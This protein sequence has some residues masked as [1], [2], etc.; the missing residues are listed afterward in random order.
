MAL[1]PVMRSYSEEM[2]P[3]D[4]FRRR[5]TRAGGVLTAVVVL[6]LFAPVASHAIGP[7]SVVVFNDL[8]SA[9]AP[10]FYTTDNATIDLAMSSKSLQVFA[11]G[12][13]GK[14]VDLSFGTFD[15]PFQA[16]VY[17]DEKSGTSFGID[18]F[19]CAAGEERFEVREFSKDASGALKRLWIV[20]EYRCE[21]ESR[22]WF[23]EVRAGMPVSPDPLEV[24]PSLVRWPVAD[25]GR[26][27]TSVP[28]S[29]RAQSAAQLGTTSLAGPQPHDFTIDD[30]GCAGKAL[31]AGEECRVWVSFDPSGPGTRAA[32]LRIVDSAGGSRAV[33]LQGFGHGGDT[34]ASLRSDPGDWAG[35]GGSYDYTPAT[36]DFFV[37][38][39]DDSY[40]DFGVG[41]WSA[42]FGAPA[43]SV[44]LPGTYV[45]ATRFPLNTPPHPGL[46][47]TGG[48][49][50]TINGS[51]TVGEATHSSGQ[52][53]NVGVTFEQHCDGAVPAL[54]GSFKFRVGDT[55]LP[56]PWMTPGAVSPLPA[57]TPSLPNTPDAVHA[58]RS[59]PR[60][61]RPL[62]AGWCSGSRFSAAKV[63][64]GSARADRLRGTIRGEV[65][66]AGAGNDRV[67]AAGGNDCLDGGSGR[68]R[69]DGGR[70]ADVIAG[71]RGNDRLI[72]GP[73]HDLLNCGPGRDVA[74]VT[75]GDRVRECERVVRAR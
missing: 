60:T 10:R 43:G 12:A 38:S 32:L 18:G 8:P 42:Q 37:E 11:E 27:G 36:A 35:M 29:I 50:N 2:R 67:R 68:D 53:Q 5:L 15:R 59:Q 22:G 13:Q 30:D 71:G 70:G 66:L 48:G 64:H 17:S 14:Y 26:R 54:R 58:P 41:G 3:G 31:A 52:W 47:V 51:F 21:N 55:T 40:V 25:F 46:S 16:G 44:L 63:R 24:T 72:G 56:A 74:Q 69:L 6:S 39:A 62:S 20:W 61:P 19:G 4:S 57:F 49:C 45:D 28:V 33:P 73:G 1:R 7:V 9:Q 65:I 23:G 75:H 34:S